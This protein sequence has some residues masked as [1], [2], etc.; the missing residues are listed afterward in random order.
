M[1]QL[2]S[3]LLYLCLALPIVALPHNHDNS[4]RGVPYFTGVSPPTT[5]PDILRGVNI[6]GWLISEKWMTPHLFS[7]PFAEASDQWT[8]D[9]TPG[10]AEALQNHWST[11]FTE[12]DVWTI[13]SYGFN[14]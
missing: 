14:A 11:Y 12:A 8:F 9:S 2:L 13:K 1:S 6:G 7:G 10:A 3:F 4:K 5:N